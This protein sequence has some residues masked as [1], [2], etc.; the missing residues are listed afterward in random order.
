MQSD[1]PQLNLLVPR[2]TAVLLK[3]IGGLWVQAWLT[4]VSKPKDGEKK[5]QLSGCFY[6][7]FIN[8]LLPEI[9]P[10]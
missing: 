6:I 4:H 1:L 8:E 2:A 10:N 3:L 7:L 9:S 5:K